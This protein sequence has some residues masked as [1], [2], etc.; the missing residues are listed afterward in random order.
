[1]DAEIDLGA[2]IAEAEPVGHQAQRVDAGG[3]QPLAALV[4]RLAEA[5]VIGEAAAAD[6]VLGL[7][8]DRVQAGIARRMGRGDTGRARAD[9]DE[10]VFVH[11]AL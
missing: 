9:D 3:V 7:K 11:P 6:P 4:E 5:V 2:A 10:V 1:M 8:N